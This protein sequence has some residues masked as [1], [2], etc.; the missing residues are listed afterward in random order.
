M[1]SFTSI[2]GIQINNQTI[3]TSDRG[4][5]LYVGGSGEGNYTKIQDA[6]NNASD[7]DTVFVYD[8]SSPYNERFTI[9]KSISLIGEDR[10]TTIIVNTYLKIEKSGV[11]VSGFTIYKG[12]IGPR[13]NSKNIVIS[14]NHFINQGEFGMSFWDTDN[15]IIDSNT[16]TDCNPSIYLD[17]DTIN[18]TISNNVF[19][20]DLTYD[21]I[22]ILC[23]GGDYNVISNN[24][25]INNYYDNYGTG[26]ELT[27]AYYTIIEGN[28][29]KGYGLLGI[30]ISSGGNL[31]TNNT[32]KN[33]Y[34]GINPMGNSN[35]IINNNF[36]NNNH[37][38]LMTIYSESN[39]ILNNNF[40]N[41]KIDASP[42]FLHRGNIWDGNYWDKYKG[43][44]SDGDGIGD[45]PHTFGWFILRAKDWHPAIEPY[46]NVTIKGC[47]I[48]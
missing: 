38:I 8:D 28:E 47:G 12:T 17:G 42:T 30:K 37:G 23:S 5:I 46:N 3:K 1:M 44:D 14:D 11:K 6:V 9:N 40:F 35:T 31:I 21:V 13:E 7:S 22:E 29:F 10:D 26:I 18:V 39:K 19:M 33:N 2:T 48:G 27:Y 41:N 15:S 45:T 16:F 36:I 43:E 24:T 32:F 4:D 20:N 34:M 25:F